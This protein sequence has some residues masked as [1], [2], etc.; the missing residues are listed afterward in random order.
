MKIIC[1]DSVR[2]LK[3]LNRSVPAKVI[4]L[5]LG[6]DSRAVATSLRNAVRDGRVKI[7]YRKGIGNYRFIRMHAG[8]QG[9]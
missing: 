9:A 3:E 2:A 7:T 6:T 5:K 1:A 8:G 4:A